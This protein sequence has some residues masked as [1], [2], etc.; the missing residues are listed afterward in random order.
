MPYYV[1]RN[2]S[3]KGW[4]FGFKLHGVYDRGDNLGGLRFSPGNEYDN[5]EV[6]NLTEGLFGLFVG[7][8]GYIVREEVCGRLYEQGR[9][10][11]RTG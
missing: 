5:Q 9:H 1:R 6:D 4:F 3:I 7:D 8:A 2:A 10:I 11:Y